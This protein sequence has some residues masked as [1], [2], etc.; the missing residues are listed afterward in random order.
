MHSS[1]ILETALKG[2]AEI[3]SDLKICLNPE[4]WML[5]VLAFPVILYKHLRTTF[6]MNNLL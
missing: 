3:D 5:I 1:H 4:V 2:F 6:M